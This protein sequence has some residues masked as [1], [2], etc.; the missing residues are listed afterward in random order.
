MFGAS[1]SGFLLT[2]SLSEADGTNPQRPS[3]GLQTAPPRLQLTSAE[4]DGGLNAG[5]REV[6]GGGGQ[7]WRQPPRVTEKAMSSHSFFRATQKSHVHLG[8]RSGYTEGRG[9]GRG[10]GRGGIW[11]TSQ[12]KMFILIVVFSWPC[13]V[14]SL[15]LCRFPT[16][17]L[18][19]EDFAK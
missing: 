6:W 4:A 17:H 12:S 13:L 5:S 2:S 11:E 7:R 3:L 15:L 10:R 8:M 16:C 19:W 18:P 1:A 14:T 9:R